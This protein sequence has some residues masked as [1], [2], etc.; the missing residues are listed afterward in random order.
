[1]GTLLGFAGVCAIFYI[2]ILLFVKDKG[3]VE[4]IGFL[5]IC[6]IGLAAVILFLSFL[7]SP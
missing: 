5:L 1:M 3:T 7:F 4:G 2:I 6:L